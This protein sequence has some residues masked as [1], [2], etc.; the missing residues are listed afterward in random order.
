MAYRDEVVALEE[1]RKRL[2]S[3]LKEVDEHLRA[4][5]KRALPLLDRVRIPAPCPVPWDTMIGDDKVRFC[6]RCSKSVFNLSAMTRAEAEQI[7]QASGGDLCAQLRVRQD[8]T[9]LTSD[10]AV[11]ARRKRLRRVVT[12]GIGAAVMSAVGLAMGNRAP[13]PA[14]ASALARNPIELP[15][16]SASEGPL[17]YDPRIDQSRLLAGGIKPIHHSVGGCM[18]GD[19]LCARVGGAANAPF[20]RGAAATALASI[21]VAACATPEGPTGTG[22]VTLT[23]SPDGRLSTAVAEGAPF[24]RTPVG[25]CVVRKFGGVRVPAYSGGDVTV[26]KSFTLNAR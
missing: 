21:D 1:R 9:V 18:E 3:E 8:G 17:T 14:G 19:P 7:L 5:K 25:A 10:C 13:Q 4:A 23:F 11:V 6:T 16:G 15:H 26:G 24:A 20:D 22:H 12:A 2:A